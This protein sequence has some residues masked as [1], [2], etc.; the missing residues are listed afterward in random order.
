MAKANEKENAEDDDEEDEQ[1]Y[2]D[3]EY[4][5]EEEEKATDADEID[6][7]LRKKYAFLWKERE[8]M[9][10]EERRWKWVK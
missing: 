1:E 10:A 8:E 7:K 2:Y 5:E 9:T 4:D 6:T 3:E